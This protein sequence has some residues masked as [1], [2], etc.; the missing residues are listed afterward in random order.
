MGFPSRAEYEQIIYAL[1]QRHPELAELASTFPH[2]FHEP[3]D[4]KHNRKSAPGVSFA[5]PN[6]DT[7]VGQVAR[8]APLAAD[9]INE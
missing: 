9:P 1:P 6:L 5:G 3:L 2:H 8:L 7:V 4:I